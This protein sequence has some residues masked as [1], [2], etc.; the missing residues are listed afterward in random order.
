MLPGCLSWL[1]QDLR[2]WTGWRR[3]KERDVAVAVQVEGT[4]TTVHE[5]T[6]WLER[7]CAHH[8]TP[9]PKGLQVVHFPAHLITTE[10]ISSA[11]S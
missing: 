8:Q 5:D 4:D 11:A 2:R 3:D 1:L 10:F 7:D 9:L 6:A